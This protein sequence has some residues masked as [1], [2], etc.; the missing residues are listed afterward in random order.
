V[1]G[2]LTDSL[3]DGRPDPSVLDRV[4][5]L[6]PSYPNYFA[7]PTTFDTVEAALG[8]PV[9]SIPTKLVLTADGRIHYVLAGA[10]DPRLYDRAVREI[11]RERL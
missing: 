10:H 11:I 9:A 4:R 6:D 8:H 1:V 2:V 5:E 3:Q 7:L